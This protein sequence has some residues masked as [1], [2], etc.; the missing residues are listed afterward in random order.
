MNEWFLNFVTMRQVCNCLVIIL[1]EI[2]CLQ[3][4][5]TCVLLYCQNIKV[6]NVSDSP[7]VQH[8][9]LFRP[10][11]FYL[12]LPNRTVLPYSRILREQALDI[13][14]QKFTHFTFGTSLLKTTAYYSICVK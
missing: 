3:Q 14:F 11:G 8:K 2:V 5:V 12:F 9:I 7:V 10:F 1:S 4:S 6:H 13:K